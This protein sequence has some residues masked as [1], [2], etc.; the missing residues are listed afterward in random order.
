MGENVGVLFPQFETAIGY[1]EVHGEQGL[2]EV[3]YVAVV[4]R[5]HILRIVWRGDDDEV[6][7]AVFVEVA[8]HFLLLPSFRN[9]VVSG[10]ACGLHP[11]CPGEHGEKR[12]CE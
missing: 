7:K 11:L 3:I 4:A 6:L 9:D 12:K 8:A 1:A 10:G 5:Q 2:V